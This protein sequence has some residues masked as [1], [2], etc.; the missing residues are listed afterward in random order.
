MATGTRDQ[1]KLLMTDNLMTHLAFIT[2]FAR[3]P[4]HSEDENSEGENSSRRT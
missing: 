4:N 2:A 1:D 3:R